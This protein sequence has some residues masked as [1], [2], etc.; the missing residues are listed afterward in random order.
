M[1]ITDIWSWLSSNAA[2]V[3]AICALVATFW[4]AYISRQH[5][6]L[7]VKPYLTTWTNLQDNETS[8]IFTVDILNN[9]VGPALIKSFQIYVNEQEIKGKE[10]ELVKKAFKILFPTYPSEPDYAYMTTGYM[11]PPG[12]ECHLVTATFSA[13][14]AS[15]KE[16]IEYAK[17]SVRI[18][19]QYE[20]IYQEQQTFDSAEVGLN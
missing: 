7:S 16:E 12:G 19:I 15:V 2:N 10:D 5:N 14:I 3:I 11:M 9:G 20:S 4:Q 8:L 17:G 6:K 13:P 18:V 1:C